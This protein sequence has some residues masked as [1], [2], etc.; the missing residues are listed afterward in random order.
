MR[1]CFTDVAMPA[2]KQMIP[3]RGS[4]RAAAVIALAAAVSC[5]CD[6]PAT[7][8]EA[9]TAPSASRLR[10]GVTI[11][12]QRWLVEQIGGDDVDVVCLIG[13]QDDPHSFQPSDAT[14]SALARCQV[15]FTIGV[16]AERGRWHRA[17]LTSSKLNFVELHDGVRFRTME[18]ACAHDHHGD[19]L[20]HHDGDD[21][22]IWLSP[23]NLLSMVERIAVT[24]AVFDPVHDED[25][26]ARATLLKQRLSSL[27]DSLRA[28]FAPYDGR[29]V[30]VF[31]PSWGYF[32]DA[33][34]LKQVAVEVGGKDPSDAELTG[35]QRRAK[36]SGIRTIFSQPQI[37]GKSV[38]ALAKTIG[39]RVEVIDPLLPD[40]A[41]NLEDVAQ[42]I[43]TSFGR[44]DV[45]A[46]RGLSDG[47]DS[48]SGAQSD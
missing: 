8:S 42:K 31:H 38:S 12:P 11:P 7:E 14:V 10:V 41:Q 16:P 5:G 47:A 3:S 29:E 25:Y 21:P 37:V 1:S 27:D 26:H 24:L 9:A 46:G 18:H 34:G 22:H 44:E 13:P 4:V 15:Y 33:Y 40:V 39:G 17:L 36:A 23:E 2:V 35:L 20:H 43:V 6:R 19:D 32:L 45:T 28:T 30:F 48:G